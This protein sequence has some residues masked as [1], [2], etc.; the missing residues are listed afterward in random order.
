MQGKD[1]GSGSTSMHTYR[2]RVAQHTGVSRAQTVSMQ[3]LLCQCRRLA[4]SAPTVLPSCPA[5]AVPTSQQL[6]TASTRG[7]GSDGYD[8]GKHKKWFLSLQAE[9]E[10][11]HLD[12][13]SSQTGKGT[14]HQEERSHGPG[15]A[16]SPRGCGKTDGR[17]GSRVVMERPASSSHC[18]SRRHNTA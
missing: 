11:S 13:Y 6:P 7:V 12:M 18:K 9:K 5:L 3:P 1:W 16:A 8:R 14:R 10:V 4:L 2:R 15:G 17:F